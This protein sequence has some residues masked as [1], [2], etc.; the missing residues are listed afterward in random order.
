MTT[1]TTPMQ[2]GDAWRY[3]SNLHDPEAVKVLVQAALTAA[4]TIHFAR[5]QTSPEGFAT[6]PDWAAVQRELVQALQAVG[7]PAG[8]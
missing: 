2:P 8:G 1:P 6:V 3:C 7:H 5:T 4:A